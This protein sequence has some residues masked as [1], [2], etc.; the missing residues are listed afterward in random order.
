MSDT[1]S[2]PWL[3]WNALG[4]VEVAYELLGAGKAGMPSLDIWAN[5]LRAIDSDGTAVHELPFALRLSKRAVRTRAAAA[6]RRGWIEQVKMG[7]G[8]DRILLTSSGAAVA[9][10]WKTLESAAERHWHAEIGMKRAWRLR[11]ALESVVAAFPLEHPHYP[12]SYGA[13]DAR[14]TGG[15]GND[16]KAVPRESCSMVSNLPWSALISQ[17]LVAFAMDYE[18]M[19]PVALSL[20]ATIIKQI[21]ADGIL[22]SKLGNSAGVSALVRHGFLSTSIS[23]GGDIAF[24]TSRGESVGNLFE[25]RIRK[26]EVQWCTSIG[27][28]RIAAL[29]EALES[30]P[31]QLDQ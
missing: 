26:V 7:R 29:R 14:V 2:L 6:A 9:G 28:E 18:S 12:A 25:T 23:S 4:S 13:A 1:Y 17:A 19:S 21:P 5:L 30:L 10:R 15:N 11:T 22:L 3:L 20:S 16:W 24:L 8:K 27:D 31:Q